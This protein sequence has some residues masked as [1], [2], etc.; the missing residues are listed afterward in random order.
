MKVVALTKGFYNGAPVPAG[1]V[2]EVADGSK[3]AWYTPVESV[4]KAPPAKPK[5]GEPQA[6][7]QIGKEPAK[8]FT[9]ALA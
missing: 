3:A 5:K 2:F 4:P 7:S 9:D 8:S 1:A 6:L